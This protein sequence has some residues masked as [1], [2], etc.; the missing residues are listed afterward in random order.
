LR[1]KDFDLLFFRLSNC[2]GQWLLV[3]RILY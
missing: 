2:R 3:F 1:W